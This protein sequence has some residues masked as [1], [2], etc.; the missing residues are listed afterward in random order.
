MKRI[1]IIMAFTVGA[2][3]PCRGSTLLAHVNQQRFDPDGFFYILGEPPSKF[4]YIGHIALYRGSRNLNPFPSGVLS[5]K[6]NILYKFKTLTVTNKKLIFTTLAVKGISYSF[7]GR[8]LR[9]GVF[10]AEG[11]TPTDIPYLKGRLRKYR[12]RKKVAEAELTFTYFTGT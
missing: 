7:A 8:F 1:L 3:S 11:D 4:R 6:G 2:L 9:G 10:A 12:G 5:S